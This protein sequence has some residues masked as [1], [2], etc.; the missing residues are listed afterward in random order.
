MPITIPTPEEIAAMPWHQR[1]RVQRTVRQLLA[2]L[3]GVAS[4]DYRTRHKAKQKAEVL[5]WARD[6]R[7][8]AKRLERLYAVELQPG[9]D[10][11]AEAHVAALLKAIS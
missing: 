9:G 10:P 1:Q 8:E 7:R 2:T 11:D 6:V 4:Q 5:Q 3:N